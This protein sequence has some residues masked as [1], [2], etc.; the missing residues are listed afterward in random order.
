MLGFAI[1]AM[2]YTNSETALEPPNKIPEIIMNYMSGISNTDRTIF[3]EAHNTI[4]DNFTDAEQAEISKIAAELKKIFDSAK[5]RFQ[6]KI[7][8]VTR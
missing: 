1:V 6:D 7:S 3:A 8:S 2:G 4:L 5:K